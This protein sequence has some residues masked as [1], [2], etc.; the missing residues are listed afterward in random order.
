MADKTAIYMIAERTGSAIESQLN[1]A[2]DFFSNPKNANKPM[3]IKM[4]FMT[5]DQENQNKRIYKE[6]PV[7]EAVNR[8][9]RLI[10]MGHAWQE[11]GH[12]I[13]TDPRRFSAILQGNS[14]SVIKEMKYNRATRKVTGWIETLMNQKG[15]EYKDIFLYNNVTP[16]TSIRALG[17]VKRQGTKNIVE[18][19]L[20]LITSDIVLNP[21]F[22]SATGKGIITE[23]T[24][25]IETGNGFDDFEHVITESEV[26]AMITE[27]SENL[28][29]VK[30]SLG[31]EDLVSGET[32]IKYNL[33]E[34][35]AIICT[36]GSCLTVFLEDHINE[37]FN[38]SF[39]KYL[40]V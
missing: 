25:G 1:E 20:K 37:E 40:G 8:F 36:S 34:N 24:T 26:S 29:M 2:R 21:S 6:K 14:V 4:E 31:V 18:N 11:E 17:S 15:K 23:S 32:E 13:T 39:K 35:T 12:P 33:K 16:A 9:Q 3:K 10:Q 30:E 19:N 38:S 22:V 7:V 27:L 28:D 5:V